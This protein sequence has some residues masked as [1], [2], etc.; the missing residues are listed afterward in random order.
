MLP[1]LSFLHHY[2]FSGEALEN[3]RNDILRHN[4]RG[5]SVVSLLTG[6]LL[7]MFA[8]IMLSAKKPV[9]EIT[10]F[11]AAALLEFLVFVYAVYLI[12]LRKR[13]MLRFYLG[14]A[15][16]IL[17]LLPFGIYAEVYC[18]QNEYAVNF[19]TLLACFQ[20]IFLIN[21]LYKLLLD[22]LIVLIFSVFAMLLKPYEIWR[23]DVMNAV[24][25]VLAGATLSWF[26]SYTQIKA[27]L[28]ANRLSKDRDR[29]REESVRD[30][31]TGLSNRREYQ[32]AVR[33]YIS[34]SQH[35]HQTVCAIMLDVDFFKNYNDHYGHQ[36]GDE[37]LRAIGGVLKQLILEEKVFAARVGGE[38][39]IV[40]WTENRIAEAERV[41]IKLLN[42]IIAL[43]I[44]HERSPAAPYV[45][46][47]LGLY[48]LRGGSDNTAEDLY[49]EADGALYEAKARGRNCILLRDSADKTVRKV[50]VV[51]PEENLGRRE[52]LPD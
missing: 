47:S 28:T 23:V 46:A 30:E 24:I 13:T 48:V 33:F 32:N 5:L 6:I 44:P 21:S 36:K 12:R 35:V 3:C 18:K 29:F 14:F 26:I 50:E 2:S 43:A 41:A 16:F 27:M 11:V 34:A 37:V 38:E 25:A 51:S 31:L 19:M 52:A 1:P 40:L 39:F 8:V 7:C 4:V 42:M 15:A 9:V 20:L 10:V 45:T 49:R 17:I 22:A